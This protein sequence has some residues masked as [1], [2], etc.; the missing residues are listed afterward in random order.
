LLEGNLLR[1]QKSSAFTQK[2]SVF[3]GSKEE[4]IRRRTKPPNKEEKMKW[5]VT[6]V[7]LIF[8]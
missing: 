5:M 1:S 6:L 4:Y 8:I 3:G 2:T 7:Y